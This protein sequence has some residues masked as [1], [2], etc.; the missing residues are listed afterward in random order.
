MK[1]RMDVGLS[2]GHN[3]LDGDPAPAAKKGHSP[4]FRPMTVVTKRLDGSRCHMVERQ[5]STQA[6]LCYMGTQP[7][8]KMICNDFL[9]VKVNFWSNVFNTIKSI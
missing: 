8:L 9:V 3:V 7:P 5:A 2:P 6:T 4:N 1:L